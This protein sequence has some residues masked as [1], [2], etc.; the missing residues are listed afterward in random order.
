MTDLPAGWVH[1]RLDEIAEV[2]LG[3]QRSPKNHS[4]LQM[5]PYLRAANVDW[6]G[7]KLDDVKFMNF[8]DEELENYRLR[9]G[10]I[11]VGEASGSPGEV[12]KP[13]IWAD[14]IEDCCLQNTLIRVRS[15]GVEP[16]F[17]LHLL[18]H[19]ARRGA[20]VDQS[21]GVGIH[22]LGVARLASWPISLPPFS[23]QCRIV[24]S[25]EKHLSRLE[26]ADNLVTAARARTRRIRTSLLRRWFVGEDAILSGCAQG[27]LAQ[28]AR[29]A[30]GQ[31]PR[32]IAELLHGC[33]APDSLPFVKVG[34]M[35]A[36]D[37]LTIGESR[38]YIEPSDARRLKLRVWPA[39][40]IIL[41]KR[42][43]AI[44]TNKKRILSRDAA[45]DLNLMGVSP[46]EVLFSSYLWCWFE[47]LDLRGLADG[48]NVP[49][50]NYGDLASLVLPV[51][52]VAVQREVSE[53]IMKAFDGVARLAAGI[54]RAQADRLR[55]ALLR[56]AFAG[57]LVPQDPNDEP[58]SELLA[59][60]RA[61]RQAALPKQKARSS[62]TRKELAAP[63]TRVTGDDY[64][65]ETLP[66]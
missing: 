22:H 60:I 49:Q 27:S 63:P 53:A 44:A 36:G 14:E 40:T 34:D 11:V 9:P 30:G 5:R 28:V 12:G 57:R 13:A 17:L 20:F 66:L 32:G 1:V 26:A 10:D 51:P 50:I 38:T 55:T 2:R 42:G 62:R 18:R 31:T 52:S 59:R 25:V 46:T 19:E 3:R 6:S 37:G 48:S 64:R 33:A 4:G 24:E 23:E 29:I 43:G 7:L 8:T 56:E 15:F 54:E 21:R 16:K 39:G 35:N 65:Q 58:A 41:P 61:E 45:I 47:H